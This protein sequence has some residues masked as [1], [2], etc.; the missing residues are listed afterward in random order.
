MS[1]EMLFEV[2]TGVNGGCSSCFVKIQAIALAEELALLVEAKDEV[3]ADTFP[4]IVGVVTQK[5]AERSP[6]EGAGCGR[7]LGRTTVE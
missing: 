7:A 1:P 5:D 4:D 6:F 3:T 2:E